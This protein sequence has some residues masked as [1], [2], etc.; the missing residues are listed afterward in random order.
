MFDLELYKSQVEE[1]CRTLRIRRLDLVGSAARL[2]FSAA[3]DVDVLV[4]FD[5]DAGLFERYFGLKERLEAIFGRPVDV[6]EERALR[7]P[8]FIKTV[9]RDRKTIYAA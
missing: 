6:I 5:G 8:F 1:V 3:S 9:E 4:E 2:D 7:N